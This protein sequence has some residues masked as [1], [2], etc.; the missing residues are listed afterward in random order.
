MYHHHLA[1]MI[2]APR[3]T[4]FEGLLH[5]HSGLSLFFFSAVPDQLPFLQHSPENIITQ[6][7][8]TE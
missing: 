3:M 7:E 2:S 8:R 6:I 5:W 1:R 4:P